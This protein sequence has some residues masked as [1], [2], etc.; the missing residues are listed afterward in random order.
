MENTIINPSEQNN[1]IVGDAQLARILGVSVVTINR[2]KKANRI[3]FIRI[4]AKYRYVLQDVLSAMKC[5]D[6]SKLTST[7]N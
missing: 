4:G 2:L 1:L 5:E 7:T 6:Y 3:P